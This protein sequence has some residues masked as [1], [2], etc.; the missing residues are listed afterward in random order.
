MENSKWYVVVD[1]CDDYQRR[2]KEAFT[3]LT[4]KPPSYSFSQRGIAYFIEDGEV[5]LCNEENICLIGK[6]EITIKQL[7]E[8]VK[9]KLEQKNMENYGLKVY[10]KPKL[11]NVF[12]ENYK[13][14]DKRVVFA[15]K[16]D[17][18]GNKRYLAWSNDDTI[19]DSRNRFTVTV[20]KFAEEIN[21]E[22]VHLTLK[23]ISEG[24]GVGV[25]SHLIRI[26]E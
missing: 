16:T 17:L 14:E 23:D 7:E 25:P 8:L 13:G 20:W 24:K 10:D 5:R 3:S 22:L 26:K 6:I 2:L 1:Y 21:E 11:M 15:E 4:L 18:N 12:G 9:Q 19:E